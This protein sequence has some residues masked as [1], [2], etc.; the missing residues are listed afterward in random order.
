MSLRI[1]PQKMG[2]F[3]TL[4]CFMFLVFPVPGVA[5]P[6]SGNLMGFVYGEDGKS[7]L[8]NAVVFLRGVDTGN[9]YQSKPTGKT[10]NYLLSDIDAGSYVVGFKV[11]EKT[12]NVDGIVTVVEGKTDTLSLSLESTAAEDTSS[13]QEGWCCNDKKV[14]QATAEECQAR[15]G[16]YFATKKEAK[17]H[18]GIPP[19]AFFKSPTGIA[20]LIAGTA[21]G[22]LGI[23]KLVE[24]KREKE[25][26]PTQR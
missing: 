25:V 2:V 17:E 10:G 8:Q 13:T 19:A 3:L 1:F 23:Y 5:G 11:N 14:F 22:G 12:F 18:C 20:V 7:P 16:K 21:A 4:Y 15:G 6:S 9:V 24:D 26:S